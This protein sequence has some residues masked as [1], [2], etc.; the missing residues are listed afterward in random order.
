MTTTLSIFNRRNNHRLQR[1]VM[2]I[3]LL[4]NLEYN[5]KLNV[6]NEVYNQKINN[7]E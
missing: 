1:L 6:N 7:D 4:P 2:A 3:K 5:E